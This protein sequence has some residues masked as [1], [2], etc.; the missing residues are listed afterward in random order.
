M[1]WT[2]PERQGAGVGATEPQLG[3]AGA[4]QPGR[5]EASMKWQCLLESLEM[6]ERPAWKWSS[7]RKCD[8]M[9]RKNVF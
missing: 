4:S 5:G 8:A 1:L 7:I 9:N 6:E 2:G 3:V